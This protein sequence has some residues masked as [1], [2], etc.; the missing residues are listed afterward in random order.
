MFLVYKKRQKLL[1]NLLLSAIILI[2]RNLPPHYCMT[3]P[4]FLPLLGEDANSKLVE[5]VTVDV[6]DEDRV[7]NFYN[8]F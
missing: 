7:D 5:V 3:H 8:F 2:F 1:P 6:D 4:L